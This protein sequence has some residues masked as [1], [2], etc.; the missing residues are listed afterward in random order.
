M[1]Q[2]TTA[3]QFGKFVV[4]GLANTLL[5]FLIFALLIHVGVYYVIAQVIAFLIGAIQSYVVNR[6]WTFSLPGFSVTTLLR[7]LSAQLLVLALS[8]SL[9][10][11]FVEVAGLPKLLAQAIALPLTAVTNFVIIRGWALAPART[12]A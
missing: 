2:S 5:S 6:Y 7:Y 10:V 8:T 9:L 12:A 3:A 1:I 11:M 4:V